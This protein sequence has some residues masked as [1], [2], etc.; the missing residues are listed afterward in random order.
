M[1][2]VILVFT[3]HFFDK[4]IFSIRGAREFSCGVDGMTSTE[5]STK[6]FEGSS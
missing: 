3:F 4:Q 2:Q 5:K 6:T 1:Y